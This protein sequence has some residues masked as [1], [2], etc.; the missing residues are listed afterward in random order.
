MFCHML[1]FTSG[2]TQLEGI[3]VGALL[4]GRIHLMGA[5]LY[6]V[7]RAVV[8]STAMVCALVDAA[9]NALVCMTFFH[10]HVLLFVD[11]V[12]AF[13][14]ARILCT[15]ILRLCFLRCIILLYKI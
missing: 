9:V 14:A 13:P 6:T 5:D 2:L 12:V 15:G 1:Q 8:R 3:A 11:S 10:V 4:L 7:Q